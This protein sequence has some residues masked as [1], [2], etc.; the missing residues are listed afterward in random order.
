M[1]KMGVSTLYKHGEDEKKDDESLPLAIGGISD[2]ISPLEM[3]AAYG[4]IANDGLYVSP[5]FYTSVTDENGNVVLEPKQK[6][7]EA[8]TK[9]AAYITKSI[10]TQPVLTGTATYCAIS[11]MDVSAK[12][13]TTNNSYDRWL[14][15]FTPYY[16]AA[17]WFGYDQQEEIVWSGRNPAG[18]IW[19][20]IMK[21]IH[22][23]LEKKRYERPDGIVTATICKESGKLA[24]ENCSKTT[25]EVFI[26]GTQPTQKCD[27]HLKIKIC[28]ESGML[29]SEF[30]PDTEEKDFKAKPEKEIDVSWNTTY[31][32][33]MNA[34]TEICTIH[35]S[36]V[37]E[38][39]KEPE[40]PEQ[41][42]EPT[43]DNTVDNTTNSTN[44]TNNTNVSNS[45]NST[46]S[47]NTSN[48][49]NSIS[50]DT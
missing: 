4:T 33:E 20:N 22:S 29:A 31:G 16:A 40:K 8:I 32:E 42:D 15:G 37:P 43:I 10:L 45:T 47:T 18:S 39:P 25:S 44:S 11:G 23:G 41:P 21:E 19:S 1:R 30:C 5:I 9:Q 36:Q 26:K 34:P 28:K 6:Q 13:G 17:T 50:N 24:G 27:A 3:A 7:E 48:T 12:T 2:G 46:N 14:C 38:E 49:T 35:T